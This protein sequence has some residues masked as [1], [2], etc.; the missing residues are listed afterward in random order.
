MSPYREAAPPPYE[1]C[2]SCGDCPDGYP[3][4]EEEPCLCIFD[5]NCWYLPKGWR[6]TGPHCDGWLG[7]VFGG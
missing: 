2:D 1:P 3:F 6:G 5:R 4:D 7:R